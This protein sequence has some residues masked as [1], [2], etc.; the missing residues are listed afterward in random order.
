MPEPEVALPVTPQNY[1]AASMP[2]RREYS[3]DEVGFDVSW[4]D[5]DLGRMVSWEDRQTIEYRRLEAA[6]NFKNWRHPMFWALQAIDLHEAA[7]YLWQTHEQHRGEFP[8]PE[9]P[10][11]NRFPQWS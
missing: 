6:R 9:T 3:P 1:W 2:R 5:A 11:V 4:W 8:T 7:E 10:P